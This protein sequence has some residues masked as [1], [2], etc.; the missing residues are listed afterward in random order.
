[1]I[2][3]GRAAQAKEI[4]GVPP[5]AYWCAYGHGYQA[6]PVCAVCGRDTDLT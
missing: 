5:Q 2:P 4:E 6:G 3:F 1:M